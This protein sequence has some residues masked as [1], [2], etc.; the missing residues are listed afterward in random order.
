MQVHKQRK[1]RKSLFATAYSRNH[2]QAL[3]GQTVL[4]SFQSA[5]IIRQKGLLM[6][7]ARYPHAMRLMHWIVAP[8]VI[9]VLGL[10]LVMEDLPQ[11][12]RRQ[13]YS[14]HK[15]LGV[16]ILLLVLVR[17]LVRWRSTLPSPI[18]GLGKGEA[19]LAKA[20]HY[21]FYVLLLAMPISGIVMSQAGGHPVALFGLGL[22][23][24]VPQDK[25]LGKLAYEA[26]ELIG[27]GLIALLAL[28][29]VGILKHAVLDKTN[30]LKRMW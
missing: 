24:L 6:P 17:M 16:T 19:L 2:P 21:G 29:L 27:N 1:R 12:L 11:D 4:V 13:G 7:T 3:R 26:H 20:V 14:L 8:L 9:A 15:S 30:I 25:A 5:S 28:H 10:G 22:P 23:V 18:P